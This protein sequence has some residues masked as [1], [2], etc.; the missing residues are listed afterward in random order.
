[1]S[2]T[3]ATTGGTTYL[4]GETIEFT[5]TFT[6]PVTVT[7]SPTFTFTLGEETREATYAGGS[8]SLELVFSYTVQ[9][10]EI[11]SDGISW[12]ANAFELN[13]GT[14]QQTIDDTKAAALEHP[15]QREA[16][17]AHRVDADPPGE[18]VSAIMQG[19]TLKLLYDEALD[20]ASAPAATAYTL[21]AGSE[22]N[23]TPARRHRRSYGDVDLCD[24]AGRR[25]GR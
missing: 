15:A 9:A 18:P 14:I 16:L 5:A 25:R 23:R 11:D 4:E 22:Q 21:T 6:A 7:G 10:G 1:M 2:S 19:T 3:P 20:A 12:G 17:G 8:E 13:G 24:G